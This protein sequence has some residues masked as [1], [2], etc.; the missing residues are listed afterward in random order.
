MLPIY[1]GC[2]SVRSDA[3]LRL[4]WQQ[5]AEASV[6]HIALTQISADL[7]TSGAH[8]HPPAVSAIVG[9]IKAPEWQE[10]NFNVQQELTRSMV[11]SIVTTLETT[12]PVLLHQCVAERLRSFRSV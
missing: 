8:F 10:W 9:T 11:F 12:A 7:P 2:A 1:S 5:S 3:A 4:L 6:S